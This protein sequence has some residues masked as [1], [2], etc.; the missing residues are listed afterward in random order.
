ME[1]E[2]SLPHSLVPV[3]CP[4]PEPLNFLKIYLN[5][6][7]P[8]APVSPKWSLFLRYLLRIRTCT[9]LFLQYMPHALPISFLFK[10][11]QINESKRHDFIEINNLML[12]ANFIFIKFCFWRLFII[13]LYFITQKMFSEECK[14]WRGP[15]CSLLQSSVT[16][17]FLLGSYVPLSTLLFS[18]ALS[19]CAFF[20][21]IPHSWHPRKTTDKI[22]GLYISLH[23]PIISW[24]LKDS[25]RHFLNSIC[26]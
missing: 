5:I 21:E 23:F 1:H 15:L 24:K 6:I 10:E 7:L 18:N 19:L 20:S 25:G 17:G 14:S 12:M 26:S 9:F 2:G 3:T 22:I 16:S 11:K 8:S 13:S 4:F